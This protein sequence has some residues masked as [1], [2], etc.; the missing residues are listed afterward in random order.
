MVDTGNP[1]MASWYDYIY[2]DI[3]H[4][5]YNQKSNIVAFSH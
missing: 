2:N 1:A 5:K 4:D 3:R